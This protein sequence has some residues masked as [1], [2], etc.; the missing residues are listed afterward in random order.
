MA[1]LPIIKRPYEYTKRHGRGLSWGLAIFIIG[2]LLPEPLIIPVEDATRKDWNQN[3][4]WYEPWSEAVVHRGIDIFAPQSTPV[5]APIYGIILYRGGGWENGG[6]VIWM[7][8]PKWRLHYF[9]HL[10]QLDVFIF[11]PVHQGEKIGEVGNTGNARGKQPH[12][13]YSIITPIPYPWRWDNNSTYG[14]QKMFFLN[15]SELLPG[16]VPPR[17]RPNE[18]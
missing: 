5:I 11:E 2:F 4:F 14:W 18:E 3:T 9:A 7:L 13:H 12:L 15:P 17:T 10:K 1:L 6:N 16:Y 8:G